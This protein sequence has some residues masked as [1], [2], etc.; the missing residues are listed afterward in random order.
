MHLSTRAKYALRLMVDLSRHAEEGAPVQLR[1]TAERTR[2]SRSYLE[3]VAT[4]LRHASLLRS[5]SGRKGGYF[6]ARP[7]ESIRLL[8]IVEAAIGPINI[9]DCVGAPAICR[10][11]ADCESRVIW[12]LV[13]RSI[14]E[15]LAGCTLADLTDRQRLAAL[16]S[17][18]SAVGW[19]PGEPRPREAR[20]AFPAS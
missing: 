15:T 10:Q 14:V 20:T 13:N 16:V 2:L 11:A 19:P 7:P 5:V 12:L 18:A 6:M 17:S 9:S 4:A 3:Q 8:E 1:R